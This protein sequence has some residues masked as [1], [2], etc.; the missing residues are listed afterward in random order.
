[1]Q[2]IFHGMRLWNLLQHNH[3][4]AEFGSHVDKSAAHG[5]A[6]RLPGFE[7][8]KSSPESRRLSQVSN[9]NVDLA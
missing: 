5:V 1:M 8:K 7:S 2:A 3:R 4:S 6:A 9:V